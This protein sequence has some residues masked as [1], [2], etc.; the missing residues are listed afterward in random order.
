MA[1]SSKIRFEIKLPIYYNEPK[2]P[3]EPEKFEQTKNEIL[4]RFGGFSV[5]GITEGGWI[6]PD[7]NDVS[8]ELMGGFFVDIERKELEDTIAFLKNYKK[9]LKERFKQ[10]EIYIVG[11]ELY[12]I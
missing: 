7:T 1:S 2:T 6:N 11:Y 4:E 12:V 3:V 5:L 9:I 10:D 8:V